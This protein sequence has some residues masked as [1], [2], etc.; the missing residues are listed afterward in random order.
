MTSSIVTKDQICAWF[1][2][3]TELVEYSDPIREQVKL[4]IQKNEDF[5]E[6]SIKPWLERYGPIE[7]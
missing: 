6:W 7:S 4:T 5:L 2:V 1:D 3:P